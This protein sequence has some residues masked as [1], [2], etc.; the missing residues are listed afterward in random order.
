[1]SVR[2]EIYCFRASF[3]TQSAKVQ[4]SASKTLRNAM[5][6]CIKRGTLST[7]KWTGLL[8][9]TAAVLFT[10]L[11]AQGVAAQS[12]IRGQAHP[13]PKVAH[14]L[15]EADQPAQAAVRQPEIPASVTRAGVIFRDGL[16]TISAE[17]SELSQ[18]LQDVS[19]ESGMTI[20]GGVTSARVF[21]R[22]G[23]AT[24]PEVLT[25]LLAG[26]GYNIMMVGNTGDG[27]P[28][29]LLLSA[30]SGAVTP[31]QA[32]V[33]NEPEY[34]PGAIQH[35]PPEQND[36]PQTRVYQRNQ[37]LEQMHKALEKQEQMQ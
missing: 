27:A 1:L 8:V 3:F 19:R 33:Q 5:Q 15:P 34:G 11:P 10:G 23:P 25:E 29:E 21:G 35:P 28:R 6:I 12:R 9:S 26:L 32:V 13:R 17:N 16:L 37:K 14:A 24:P 31:P 4:Q 20:S 36:L 30:R 7:K 2:T 18:I 22:Y